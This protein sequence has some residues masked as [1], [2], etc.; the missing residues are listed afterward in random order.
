MSKD[1]SQ[2]FNTTTIL[3]LW[4]CIYALGVEDIQE[5]VPFDCYNFYSNTYTGAARL[6][7]TKGDG[8]AAAG[9]SV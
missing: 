6:C 7:P 1:V 8:Q 9:K 4:A 3:F 5:T 2:R